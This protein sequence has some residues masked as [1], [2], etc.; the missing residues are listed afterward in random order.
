MEDLATAI[1]YVHATDRLTQMIGMKLVSQGRISEM[2]GP[3]TLNLDIYLR[4]LNLKQAAENMYKNISPE[5]LH[6]LNRYGDG[7]NAYINA[8]TDN[9]PP[10]LALAGYTPEPWQPID[11]LMIFTLVTLSLS[12]NL[13]EEIAALDI[14]QAI[15]P[16]KTAWLLPIYPDEPLPFD[17]M[18]KLK[19]IDLKNAAKSFS[20]LSGLWPLLK[21]VG[22]S[23]QAASNNWAISKERTQEQ[24]SIFS[25]DMHLF[26]TMPSMWN[27]MHVRS[28]KFDAAGMN[29]AGIPSIVAGYNGHIAWGMTMV[30]ADNQ[31]IFLEQL[32]RIDGKLHYLY[33]GQWLPASERKEI[34]KVK[35]KDPVTVIVHET[36]HGPLMNDI[37]NKKPIHSIQARQIDLP[38][39]LALSWPLA[40]KDD[41]SLEAFFSLSSAGSVDEAI[42][43]F[44]R[45]R[46]IPLNFVLADKQNIAW[47]V[48]GN[49]PIRA[50]GRGLV[51]SP[52]WTGEY[53]WKGLLDP[54]V[55][56]HAENPPAGFVAT[57]NNRTVSK[58][59]PYVLSSSWMWPERIE[60]I[61][62]LISSTDKH[63]GKTSAEYATGYRFPVCSQTQGGHFGRQPGR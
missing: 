53:D 41:V 7:V 25:N 45:I 42:P 11:T 54:A 61:T 43:L 27:M 23:G 49:Y 51:P 31:D 16:E 50:K 35:G 58:D 24:A 59:Y 30:M 10:G 1:G 33:K 63:T 13:H 14:A 26:L 8:H 28:G 44:K 29:I 12:C 17:E 4:T 47:Q 22:L 36:I 60:R 5:R 32:K 52:G 21:T 38:Y 2:A 3:S 55:L 15:G 40:T 37:L 62:Q 39:G 9:L 56:P 34:F 19:G 57:A 46:S 20:E 18:E 48:T 6:L